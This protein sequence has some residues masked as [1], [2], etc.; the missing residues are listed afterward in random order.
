MRLSFFA[1]ICDVLPK[2]NDLDW[3]AFVDTLTKRPAPVAQEK[4]LA[5]CFSPAEFHTLHR[6]SDNVARIHLAVLDIDTISDATLDAVIAKLEPYAYVAY[7][8]LSHAALTASRP[9]MSAVRIIIALDRPVA[10]AEWPP[11]WGALNAY[12]DYIADAA[13]KDP[14][15]LYILPCHYP[16]DPEP[17]TIAHSGLPLSVDTILSTP[18]PKTHLPP[19]TAPQTPLEIGQRVDRAA[20]GYRARSLAAKSDDP[21]AQV[22][23]GNLRDLLNGKPY[24]DEGKRNRTMLSLTAELER[25]FPGASV[26]AITA[27]FEKSHAAMAS[28]DADPPDPLT[29]VSR[30]IEGARRHRLERR[31]EAAAEAADERASRIRSARGDGESHQY[32]DEELADIAHAHGIPL[33]ELYLHWI[34][35]HENRIY[36]LQKSGYSRG[37]SPIGILPI[38][39]HLLS[40]VPGIHLYNPPSRNNPTPQIR[41]WDAIMIDYG[42]DI[43][44][45][46]VFNLTCQENRFDYATRH[47][48][49]ASAPLAP[50]QPV[51]HPDVHKWLTLLGG[52]RAGQLLDWVATVPDMTKKLCAVYLAGD[53]GTGKTLF[54]HALARIW[55]QGKPTSFATAVGRFNAALTRCPL[56]VVDEGFP[57]MRPEQISTEIRNLVGSGEVSIEQKFGGT[58]VLI[59]P[60]R[61]VMCANNTSLLDFKA[62]LTHEDIEALAVRVLQIHPDRKARD[63]FKH[64]S[65]AQYQAWMDYQV[66][67]HAL[68]LKQ[69]RVVAH[70][71]GNRFAVQGSIDEGVRQVVV[72]GYYPSHACL[73]LVEY[74]TD[75]KRRHQRDDLI[76]WGGGELL[77]NQAGLYNAWVDKFPR[78]PNP[79]A[80]L[81][82]VLRALANTSTSRIIRAAGTVRRYWPLNLDL[83]CTWCDGNGY[84]SDD[85]MKLINAKLDPAYYLTVVDANTD[86]EDAVHSEV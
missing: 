1:G 39:A 12:T 62:E 38:A 75:P 60:T 58:S 83:I 68:Y 50:L 63:V 9:D 15:R 55:R 10:V 41:S 30:A 28:V 73:V 23:A 53:P 24:G 21:K 65:P 54:A 2:H 43:D 32:T 78:G 40:P 84:V 26:D 80:K 22:L 34:L 85:V 74:I 44:P 20:I 72:S 67:E 13:C 46:P 48:H 69:T 8:T 14:A 3:N 66:A 35:R 71:P 52:D 81:G 77:V 42:T 33:K 70:V 36:F 76:R 17:Q 37:Y 19:S 6:A 18:S 57:P 5:P 51:E 4:K 16:D 56:I 11:F 82:A 45:E 79:P 7:T 64:M 47:L 49:I 31:A 25:L 27:L 59:G 29:L 61:L 86:A